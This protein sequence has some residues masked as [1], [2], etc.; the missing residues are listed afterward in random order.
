MLQNF[1]AETLGLTSPDYYYYLNQSAN[2]KVEGTDDNKEF[3]DTFV[4]KHEFIRH[5]ISQK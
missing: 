3:K 4:S 5:G 2:Y 1:H